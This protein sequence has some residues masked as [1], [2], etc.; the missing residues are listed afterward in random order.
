MALRIVNKSRGVRPAHGEAPLHTFLE[1]FAGGGM[2]RAGLKADW[3][4]VFANDFDPKKAETYIDNWGKDELHVGDVGAIDIDMLPKQAADLA[5]ASFPCQ[6]LSLAG[7]GAG[8]KGERSGS[9]WPFWDRMTELK[10]AGRAP[11]MIVL[12]NVAGTLTSHDGADFTAIIEAFVTLGYDVGALMIDAQWFVPQSRQRLF[13]IGVPR[14]DA[15]RQLSLLKDE[16]EAWHT[17]ALKRAYNELPKELQKHWIWW[18]MPLPAAR[19]ATFADI[20]E[21]DPQDVKWH[22]KAETQKLL[23]MMSPVNRAKVEAAKATGRRVVG[24]MY[25]R[26]RKE[27]GKSVQRVEIRFDDVSGCLRTPGGGSSRQLLMIVEGNTVRSRLISARET[28]RLMGLDDDYKLPT[29][30]NDAYHLTGDGVVVSVVRY[31]S[32]HIL[33]PHSARVGADQKASA[34]AKVK[35][36]RAAKPKAKRKG[37]SSKAT[38]KRKKAG[39]K[40]KTQAP[41]K[42]RRQ[43]NASKR[44]AA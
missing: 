2:A 1:F 21:D 9:F 34:R 6:D 28:A 15:P 42:A 35:K 3:R 31:L 23:T 25:R 13:F 29:R 38:P 18:S 20:L 24:G 26:T 22:T 32:E 27:D 40:R 39:A 14:A 30:Y 17:P 10:A 16:D 5:W 36:P 7:A 12:E 11:K 19:N 37:K 44:K 4:C 43:A 33:I 41:K 8:L